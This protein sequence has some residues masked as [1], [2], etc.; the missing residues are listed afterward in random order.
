MNVAVLKTWLAV[1]VAPRFAKDEHG[2]YLAEYILLAALIG[3]AVIATVVFLRD[4]VG[5]PSAP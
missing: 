2:A 5:H 3:L 1:K 4:N